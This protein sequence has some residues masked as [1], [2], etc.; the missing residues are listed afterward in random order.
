M[1]GPETVIGTDDLEKG[2]PPQQMHGQRED[3]S[4]NI[5]QSTYHDVIKLKL[6]E[7]PWLESLNEFMD[8]KAKGFA[9]NLVKRMKHFDIKVINVLK[10]GNSESI[11][12]C[13]SV[14][15]F[16]RAICGDNSDKE[17]AGTLV[18][19]KGISRDMIETLGT[20]FEIEPIFF[21]SHLAGTELY[22][23]GHTEPLTLQAPAG[24]PTLLPSYI[25]KAPFYTAEYRRAYQIEGGREK[26][27]NRRAT[28]TSTPR[29]FHP[30]HSDLPDIFA[31]EKI[32]V[33]KRKGSNIGKLGLT[34]NQQHLVQ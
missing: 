16:E 12:K 10:S 30:I 14:E 29:G 2:Q 28:E 18:I 5:P 33:Y 27:F 34:E 20:R 32:S 24:A 15:D 25:R 11:I 26:V 19:A 23:M 13:S 21:A 17:Q 31:A 1:S 9:M 6:Q 7:R 3:E 4:L 8:P 22:R